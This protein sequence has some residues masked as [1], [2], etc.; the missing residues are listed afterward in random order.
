MEIVGLQDLGSDKEGGKLM[1]YVSKEDLLK[2]IQ[3]R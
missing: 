2:D 3:F 1:G